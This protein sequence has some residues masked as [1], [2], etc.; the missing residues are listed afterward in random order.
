MIR[1]FTVVTGQLDNQGDIIN[2]HGVKMPNKIQLAE[3]F[4][5]AKVIGHAELKR[6][7]DAI[8]ATAEIPDHYLDAYPAI[9]GRYINFRLEGDHWAIDELEL[10]SIGLCGN[11]NADP[12]IKSIREQIGC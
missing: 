10:L 1:T 7:G 3:G 2:I 12:T 8:K 5:P 11:P 9:R 4:D 6:E